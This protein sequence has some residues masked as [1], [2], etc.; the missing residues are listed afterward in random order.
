MS[1]A[2]I[3][4]RRLLLVVILGTTAML[5]VTSVSAGRQPDK[6]LKGMRIWNDDKGITWFFHA[7]TSPNHK[8][9]YTGTVD[10]IGARI[11]G[12]GGIASLGKGDSWVVDKNHITFRLTTNGTWDR[13]DIKLDHRADKL[14]VDL[15]EDGAPMSTDRIHI[16]KDNRHPKSNHFTLPGKK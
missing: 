4:L 12:T 16:G 10:V 2:K 11:N 1:T 14:I 13:V 8:H 6:N 7:H 9:V 15:R 5:W 3:G